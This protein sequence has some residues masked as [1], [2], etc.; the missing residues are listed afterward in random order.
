MERGESILDAIFDEDSLEDVLDVEMMDVEEGGS[1][2][3]I[4]PQAIV[5]AT[6]S[7]SDVDLVFKEIGTA[8]STTALAAASS[9]PSVDTMDTTSLLLS[10]SHTCPH[11]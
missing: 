8:T 9:L 4:W 10:T 5:L 1:Y 2:Q 3:V 6:E 11:I 7:D